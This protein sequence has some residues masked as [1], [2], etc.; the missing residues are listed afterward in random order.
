MLGVDLG[1]DAYFNFR[2]IDVNKSNVCDIL[3]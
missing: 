3:I 1:I 2:D